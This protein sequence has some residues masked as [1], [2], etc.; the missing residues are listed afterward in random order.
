MTGTYAGQWV[1]SGFLDLKVSL[2]FGLEL[3][4]GLGWGGVLLLCW[5]PQLLACLLC[6]APRW[7]VNQPLPS[8]PALPTHRSRR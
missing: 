7:N 8:R 4:R 3:I 2:G 6:A 5:G 1:M